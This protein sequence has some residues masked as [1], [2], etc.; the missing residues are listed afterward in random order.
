[1]C[2]KE[3]VPLHIMYKYFKGIFLRKVSILCV[4][5]FDSTNFSEILVFTNGEYKL[6]KIDG[7]NTASCVVELYDKT[8]KLLGN[9]NILEYR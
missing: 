6:V 7:V 3:A 1:M 5:V 4:N 9:N 8:Y 2:F